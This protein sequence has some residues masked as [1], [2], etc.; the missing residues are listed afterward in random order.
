MNCLK[1]TRKIA[2][3]GGAFPDCV[4][5][6]AAGRARRQSYD[7]VEKEAECHFP[8]ALGPTKLDKRVA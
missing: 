8:V 1:N 3:L 2:L 7:F 6:E 5:V 4:P